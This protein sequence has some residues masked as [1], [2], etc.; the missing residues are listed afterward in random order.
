MP[1]MKCP[2]CE[3]TGKVRD[4]MHEVTDTCDLC[5]GSGEVEPSKVFDNFTGRHLLL[6][7]PTEYAAKCFK[8]WLS[9]GGGE[10]SYLN[11]QDISLE[12]GDI[13][14]EDHVKEI[15]YFTGDNTVVFK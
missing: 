12:Q 6:E 5:N 14:P 3:G 1:T 7:F 10:Q 4:L 8:S 11:G 2:V 15:D 9:D 13:E